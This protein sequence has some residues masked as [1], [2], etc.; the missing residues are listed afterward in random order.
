VLDTI[1]A[2]V[3]G[4]ELPGGRSALAFARTYGG[5]KELATVIG[6]TVLCGPFEAAVLSA[7]TGFVSS[8][9]AWFS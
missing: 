6:D 2:I 7:E 5:G 3:S 1:A 9:K 4:T 8:S